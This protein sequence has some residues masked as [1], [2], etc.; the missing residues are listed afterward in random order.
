ML[1]V[2]LQVI[3]QGAEPVDYYPKVLK[4]VLHIGRFVPGSSFL[5]FASWALRV[6]RALGV[7]SS[8]GSRLLAS[9]G[10]G[11]S[12]VFHVWEGEGSVR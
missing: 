11:L 12:G 10:P 1:Q 5:V 7:L 6:L 9:R 4:G 8:V 3:L 2:I